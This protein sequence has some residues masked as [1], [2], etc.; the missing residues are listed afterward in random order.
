MRGRVMDSRGLQFAIYERAIHK[1]RVCNP[2]TRVRN[3]GAPDSQSKNPG[4]AKPHP[5]LYC[6]TPLG[7]QASSG[8][9]I[10]AGYTSVSR[11]SRPLIE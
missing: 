7:F 4:F 1:L 2:R 3:P 9:R 10:F 8:L 6:D 11:S 5:G